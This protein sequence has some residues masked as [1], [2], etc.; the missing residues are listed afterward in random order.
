MENG[1]DPRNSLTQK[2]IQEY[3]AFVRELLA[4]GRKIVQEMMDVAFSATTKADESFVTAVDLAIETMVREEVQKRFPE[5]GVLGEELPTINPNAEYRW[6]TDP[7]DGTQ[8]LVHR[9]PTFGCIVGLH[10]KG[11][12]VVGGIDHPLLD[13][14]Y[15]A[16]FGLGAW[17]NQMPLQIEDSACEELDVNE[18]VALATRAMFERSG[19]GEQFDAFMAKH[20]STRVFYDCFSTTRAV[21]GQIG[22]LVEYNVRIWDLAATEILITEAGGVFKEIKVLPQPGAKEPLRSVIIGKPSVVALLT[23]QFH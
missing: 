5:H 14:C 22:A 1:T 15:T 18:I 11:S 3:L 16:G 23:S 7:I 9:L 21:A 6:I 13:L 12:P 8:N 17:E 4:K 10:Y 19:E 2:E 20:P